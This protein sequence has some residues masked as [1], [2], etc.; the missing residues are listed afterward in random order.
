MIAVFS[1][2]LILVL[3]LFVRE[4]LNSERQ[5]PEKEAFDELEEV[6]AGDIV[7]SAESGFYSEDVVLTVNMKR[8]GIFC[9]H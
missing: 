6:N 9:I 8:P 7:L 4:D 2:A 5:T 3:I 1:A